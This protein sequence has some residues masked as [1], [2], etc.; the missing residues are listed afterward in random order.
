PAGPRRAGRLPQVHHPAGA[1]GPPE[2]KGEAGVTLTL[3]R[4]AH[5]EVVLNFGPQHPA[6]HGTL[7]IVMHL[8]GERIVRALPEIGFLHTGFEKLGEHLTWQQ[9]VTVTDRMNYFSPIS[10]NIAW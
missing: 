5:D 1:G 10:N 6:T 8:D 7:R 9:Y 4:V 2:A 3:D